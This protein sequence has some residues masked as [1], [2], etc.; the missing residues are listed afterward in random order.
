MRVGVTHALRTNEYRDRNPQ[1]K[2]MIDALGLRNV[3]VWD[4]RF[5]FPARRH[6]GCTFDIAYILLQSRKFHIH[7]IVQTKATLVREQWLCHWLGRSTFSYCPRCIWCSMRSTD[8]YLFVDTQESGGEVSPSRPS[9]HLCFNKVHRSLKCFWNGTE[10]GR[11]TRRLS[12]LLSRGS[13]P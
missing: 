8:T 1:Y 4:F 5:A 7:A 11:P 3:G 9:A 12:I 10:Y 2:W 13:G 6:I